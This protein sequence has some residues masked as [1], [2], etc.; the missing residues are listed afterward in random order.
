MI[1]S[2]INILQVTVAQC[3]L[4]ILIHIMPDWQYDYC[5]TG[6]PNVLLEWPT[7]YLYLVWQILRVYNTCII[8]VFTNLPDKWN[9]KCR[10]LSHFENE[11]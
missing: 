6:L 2:D 11:S 10:G 9:F 8:F 7:S 3:I 4:V 5:L 1:T